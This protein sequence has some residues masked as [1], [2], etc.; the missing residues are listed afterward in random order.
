MMKVGM[1]L[2]SSWRL[3][4]AVQRTPKRPFDFDVHPPN[5]VAAAAIA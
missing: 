2:S 4:N 5:F 3:P 1:R